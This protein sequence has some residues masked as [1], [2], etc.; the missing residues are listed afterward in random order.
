MPSITISFSDLQE[1]VETKLPKDADKLNDILQFAKCEVESLSGDE[2]SLAVEDGNRPDLWCAEGIARE[3]RGHLGVETGLKSCK[4][5]KS[6]YSVLV[7]AKLQK[8]RPYIAC[9]AVKGV[10]LSD[11]IV[12][13]LMQQ[14]EKIDS[15]YGRGRRKS[16]VGIYD[17]EKIK[18]PLKYTV[19]LPHE[20][21]FV[22]LGFEKEMT[23]KEILDNHPKGKDYGIIIS[24]LQEFPIFLDA[25][26][27]VLSMP[28][29][30]NSNDSGKI[31]EKTKN[32]FIEVTGTDWNVVQKTLL[33]MVL[34]LA[35]RGGEIE[36]VSI[37]YIYDLLDGSKKVKTPQIS[38]K[39]VMLSAADANKVL[40]MKLK[41]QEIKKLLEK[42]RYGVKASDGQIEV[43]APSY[44]T[45]IMHVVDVIEDIAISYGFDNIEPHMIGLPTVGEL[46]SLERFSDKLRE[47]LVGFG[48]QE[49]MTFTLTSNESQFS[50]MSYKGSAI[51]MQNPVSS[52][53]SSL[54]TWLLPG[55]M[56]FLASNKHRDFPQKIFEVGECVLPD[57]AQET[58]AKTARKL[59][60][61]LSYEDANLTEM[62]SVAE[63]FLNNLHLK[64]EIRPYSHPSFIESRCAEVLVNEKRVGVFGEVSLQ[65]LENW[66]L[67]TPTIAMEMDLE[68]LRY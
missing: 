35:D 10:K 56:S 34:S 52:E 24:G 66:G 44:R 60:A 4:A 55:L 51:E 14:Q 54:R 48:L 2:L 37:E 68:G 26:S 46:S 29:I 22:P 19:T 53:F 1:L 63:A 58:K 43:T 49:I 11:T 62:K 3:L 41:D 33:I 64:Y 61:A 13:Q 25:N 47:L 32:V 28:P 67:E 15:T 42:A 18:F 31:T 27:K 38:H 5:K 23:P 40:G 21:A 36:E 8:T 59:A 7:D 39:S 57:E 12:R 9:A 65:V 6:K 20:N 30:T 17:L 45:D 50:K 16:S